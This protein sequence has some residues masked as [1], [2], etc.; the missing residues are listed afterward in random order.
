MLSWPLSGIFDALP[1]SGHRP[2]DKGCPFPPVPQPQT[3]CDGL[4]GGSAG[5]SRDIA[6]QY[7]AGQWMVLDA[8]VRALTFYGGVPR[9]VIID[10]PKTMVT[11][12]SRS[13][14]RVFHPRFL[15]L[16]LGDCYAITCQPVDEPLCDGAVAI[17]TRTNGATLTTLHPGLR[18][19]EGAS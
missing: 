10:N 9:R 16:L 19:G 8:F 6:A 4:S 5:P 13:K 2:E 3:F 18:L 17:V 12:V 7:P 15:A 11:Y 1:V 14:D